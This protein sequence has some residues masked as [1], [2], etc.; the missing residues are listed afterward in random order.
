MSEFDRLDATALA[1]LVR[2]KK[3]SAR[4]LVEHSIARI[5]KLN[6]TLNAVVTPMFESALARAD[7]P[8]GDGPFAGVPFLVKD[9]LA[10]VEG[11]RFTS[12][13]RMLADFVAHEDSVLIERLRRAGFIF[14]G[15]TN[16]PEFGFL[17]TTE[18]RLFGACKNPW[19]LTRT[20]GGSSGGSAAAVAARIVPAAHA[21]D[22]GGSTR[23][24]A[25]CCG[26]FGLKP[27]RGRITLAPALGDVMGGTAW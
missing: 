21:N 12:G 14:V 20:T 24:P 11:V 26:L 15:K 1:E 27:T 25:S 3:A 18:P 2:T 22:G 9:I 6:P 5:E 17:P 16:V 13:S 7:A 10:S 23:I 4:E 8:V 19:D